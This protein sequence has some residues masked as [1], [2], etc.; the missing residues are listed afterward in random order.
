MSAESVLVVFAIAK[1][2]LLR[3]VV[4]GAVVGIVAGVG[5]SVVYVVDVALLQQQHGSSGPEAGFVMIF[6]VVGV[7]VGPALGLVSGVGAVLLMRLRATFD[8]RAAMH[9]PRTAALGAGVVTALSAGFAL[10]A[11]GASPPMLMAVVVGLG[12][13]S[14][15]IAF[16]Q[17]KRVLNTA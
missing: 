16:H 15:I 8:T 3:S 10:I 5:L 13:V 2:L 17:T 6:V 9:Y 4:I 11:N 1:K 12:L 14:A 7:V